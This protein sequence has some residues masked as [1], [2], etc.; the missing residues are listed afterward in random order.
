MHKK[1]IE[2]LI[3]IGVLINLFLAAAKLIAGYMGD[4]ISLQ[5]DGYNSLI[6]FIM[7]IGVLFTIKIS[8]KQ[9]D[10]DHPYG[11]QKFEGIAYFAL[12]MIFLFT[13]LTIAFGVVKDIYLYQYHQLILIK[14]MMITLY[15]S[16]GAMAIK[17]FLAIFYA[18]LYKK[19]NHPTLKA[20]YKNHRLDVLAT[21]C[22]VIG[23]I[24]SRYGYILFDY[25]SALVIAFIMVKLAVSTI[26]EAIS[27]I[28]DQAPEQKMIDDI[29]AF[30]LTLE[31]VKAIDELKI[32]KHVTQLYIDVEI[33][34]NRNYSL[35]KAHDIAENVHMSIEH[36]YLEVI[37]CM[38]HVNPLDINHK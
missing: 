13:A 2:K 5:T 30:I 24:L 28:V 16:L 25:A 6:D 10:D 33:A 14:P 15:V 27:F 20:E 18:L 4:S 36:K 17:I 32:R 31:G 7:S 34:V 19:T 29:Y 21:L 23:I 3:W 35:E 37:H 9:P 26:K 11:H 38:V 12:G 1:R 8:L 22:A